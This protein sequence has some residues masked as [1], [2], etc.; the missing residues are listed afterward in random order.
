MLAGDKNISISVIFEGFRQEQQLNRTSMTLITSISGIRGTIGGKPGTGLT[1]PDIIRYTS[2][3][4]R[5]AQTQSLAA[6]CRNCIVVGRDARVSGAI[7]E[8]LVTATLQALGIDVILAGLATTPTVEMAVP[9]TRALAGIILTASHNPGHWNALKLLNLQGEFLSAAEGEKII[10]WSGRDELE[11]A[12]V[13]DL[14]R[15]EVVDFL[16]Y[17]IARILDLPYV[18]ARAIARCRF[19]VALDAVNSVGG[20]AVPRLLSALGVEDIIEIHCEPSGIFAHN[21]EPLPAHLQDLIEAVKEKNADVGFAVDP[22]VDRLAMVADG[23]GFFGEEYTLVAAAD[24][25]LQKRPGP[26]VSNLSSSRALQLV[27]ERYGQSYSAAAVGEVNVVTEMKR[28]GAVIGGEGNGGVILPELHYGRDSLVGIA[29]ILSYLAETGQ[30]LSL[31][32]TTYP[33]LFMAKMKVELTTGTNPIKVLAALKRAYPDTP[34][35][36]IDGLKL[37][38][39]DYWVHIRQSN[40]EPIMRVYTEAFNPLDAEQTAQ[41]FVQEILT[42]VKN[43]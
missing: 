36:T 19:R 39:P 27:T 8:S 7:V 16:D 4:G 12:G 6:G 25:L 23:G 1:P 31:L 5:W 30:P 14:G 38:F 13:S 20:F 43:C 9:H 32:R 18:D 41:R 35:T 21:P 10:E 42:I 24:Y 15:V 11:Y 33:D 3:F 34:S 40:T 2:A 28:V 26:T 37:D 22:D 29:L 17:H